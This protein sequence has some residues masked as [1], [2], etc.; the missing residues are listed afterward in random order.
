MRRQ[1]E[2]ETPPR[3]KKIKMFAVKRGIYFGSRRK[4]IWH[5]SHR[6]HCYDP[7]LLITAKVS[8]LN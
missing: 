1:I 8:K 4:K 2:L 6:R 3:Q 5:C 7:S